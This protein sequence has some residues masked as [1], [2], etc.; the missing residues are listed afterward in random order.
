M[1]SAVW[2]R[3]TADSDPVIAH[4]EGVMRLTVTSI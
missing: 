1:S 3:L 2:Q 4:E